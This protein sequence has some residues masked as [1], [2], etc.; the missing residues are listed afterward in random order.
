MGY[1]SGRRY[2]ED[3]H[4]SPKTF[5]DAAARED[6]DRDSPRNPVADPPRSRLLQKRFAPRSSTGANL[7]FQQLVPRD[8]C[9][10]D[11]LRPFST[12][13]PAALLF[14]LDIA[15]TVD[16]LTPEVDQIRQELIDELK[17]RGATTVS[18]L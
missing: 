8:Y 1:S 11:R 10:T 3:P 15:G 6:N 17:D 7:F 14:S 16:P 5:I 12:A 13:E 18:G 2:L 9:M 4:V